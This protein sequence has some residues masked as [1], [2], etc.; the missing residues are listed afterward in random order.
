MFTSIIILLIPFMM[1]A[2]LPV[3][4][5]TCFTADELNEMGISLEDSGSPSASCSFQESD[6]ALPKMTVACMNV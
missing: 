6:C 3:T 2:V 4:I 5:N 1:V